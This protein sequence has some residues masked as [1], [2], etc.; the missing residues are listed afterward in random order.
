MINHS[1]F[2]GLIQWSGMLEIIDKCFIIGDRAL[3]S[4]EDVALKVVARAAATC[5]ILKFLL[6]WIC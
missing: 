2:D 5:W 3:L 1:A 6:T 4:F